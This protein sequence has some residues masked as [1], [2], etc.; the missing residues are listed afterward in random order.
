MVFINGLEIDEAM[1]I[2]QNG[3]MASDDQDSIWLRWHKN[4]WSTTILDNQ[5]LWMHAVMQNRGGK[6]A[7]GSGMIFGKKSITLRI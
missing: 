7:Q 6:T 2:K 3:A 4:V 5:M 1:E